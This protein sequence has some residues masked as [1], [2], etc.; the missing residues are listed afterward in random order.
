MFSAPLSN[1]DTFPLKVSVN[2]RIPYS[3]KFMIGRSSANNNKYSVDVRGTDKRGEMN[4]GASFGGFSYEDQEQGLSPPDDTPFNS[5]D[6]AGQRALIKQRERFGVEWQ[7]RLQN[8][9]NGDP[10]PLTVPTGHDDD[11]DGWGF[12]GTD[13]YDTTNS[14]EV[15]KAGGYTGADELFGDPKTGLKQCASCPKRRECWK[16]AC[17]RTGWD[18]YKLRAEY[19]ECYDTIQAD[20][21]SPYT[22]DGCDGRHV[23]KYCYNC[24]GQQLDTAAY[25]LI[26]RDQHATGYSFGQFLFLPNGVKD[27]LPVTLGHP[28]YDFFRAAH[29]APGRFAGMLH[30]NTK[31]FDKSLFDDPVEGYNTIDTGSDTDAPWLH[32]GGIA[33]TYYKTNELLNMGYTDDNG[34]G[35]DG[36]IT[37]LGFYCMRDEVAPGNVLEHGWNDNW[38][39]LGPSARGFPGNKCDAW[40]DAV[41]DLEAD[42]GGR[43][44]PP[45]LPPVAGRRLE[46][47]SPSPEPKPTETKRKLS[48]K[49]NNA[50]EEPTYYQCYCIDQAMGTGGAGG[51]E[52]IYDDPN[53]FNN[54]PITM[55]T[56]GKGPENFFNGL[57]NVEG[58]VI[59]DGNTFRSMT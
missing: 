39:A 18:A 36:G 31:A 34:A 4:I 37:Q 1:D 55:A 29:Y 32:T 17:C 24:A 44:T 35:R 28:D 15:G 54:I 38:D 40:E 46:N 20:R 30:N 23:G 5:G 52:Y 47:E 14:W 16:Q 10:G 53:I 42:L 43:D 25:Q 57:I 50:G 2:Q 3:E 12:G 26:R 33:S 51:S 27:F 22:L 7:K 56:G 13:L 6:Y 48:H 49:R 58:M 21:K 9:W 59:F 11:D 8:G 19:D 41:A 45:S